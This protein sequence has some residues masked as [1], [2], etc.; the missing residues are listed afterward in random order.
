MHRGK[1]GWLITCSN[2]P[3]KFPFGD[4]RV[5][6]EKKVDEKKLCKHMFNKLSNISLQSL[7]NCYASQPQHTTI[8]NI[9]EKAQ[10]VHCTIHG[11][12][13]R[14]PFSGLFSTTTWVSQHQKG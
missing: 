9:Y 7:T 6:E 14:H 12:T 5:N 1:H 3:E 13:D 2:F 11:Q 10:Y 8:C 4:P